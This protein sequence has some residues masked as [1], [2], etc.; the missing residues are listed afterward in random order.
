LEKEATMAPSHKN[1][2]KKGKDGAKPNKALTQEKKLPLLPKG[3]EELKLVRVH[4]QI[5]LPRLPRKTREWKK[6]LTQMKG[7]Q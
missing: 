1:K 5:N 7:H 3:R 4:K 6:F 2:K